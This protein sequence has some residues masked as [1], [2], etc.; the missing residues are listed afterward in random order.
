MIKRC[1]IE[2][3]SRRLAHNKRAQLVKLPA[4]PVAKVNI[5]CG[6]S[7]APGWINVDGSLNAWL[8]NKPKWMRAVG[9]RA[10]GSNQY[11][12]AEV[13]EQTLSGNR[14]VFQDITYGL[15][16]ADG[17]IDF[18]F[19]SHFVEHLSRTQAAQL[20]KECWRV[21]KPGGIARIA[22][23]DLEYAWEL[24]RRGD[25]ERMLH[26]YFFTDSDTAFSQHR[27]AYDFEL[28][29]KALLEAGFQKVVRCQFQQ[30]KTPDLQLLDNRG[31]YSLFVEA[32]CE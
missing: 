10:S 28:M 21:L 22:V 3:V 16:F 2:Y 26:D 32:T 5:G 20:L 23:P 30:G 25:K 9:Y 11:Y 24:Y 14:F 27:Y 12:S 15:P 7:V 19:S 6:L 17:S 18:V 8:A 1:L 29:E 31:E 4:E 13:Y